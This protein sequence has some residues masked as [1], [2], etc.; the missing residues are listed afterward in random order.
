[1]PPPAAATGPLPLPNSYWVLPGSLLA[2]VRCF[3]DLTEP[4][5]L[6]PYEALLPL[7]CDYFRRPIPDHGVPAS[8][9]HLADIL[10]CLRQALRARRVV[11]LHCR[12]GIGR[13]GLV[14]ACLLTEQG[15]SAE[16]ALAELNRRWSLSG[17]AR[18]W[19]SVPESGL[20]TEYVRR[21]ARHAERDPLFDPDTLAAARGLRGRFLGALL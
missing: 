2:G 19:P 20:Q 17:R 6:A 13:T 8:P 5:E 11:Y 16:E 4:D 3:V 9:A 10:E 21:W 7:D 12:A 1:M 15:L 18:D 14:A